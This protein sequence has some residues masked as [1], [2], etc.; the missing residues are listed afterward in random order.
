M[1]ATRLKIFISSVKKEFTDIRRDLKASN[2]MPFKMKQRQT[3][4]PIHLKNG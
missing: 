2:S 3:V 1:P 4:L